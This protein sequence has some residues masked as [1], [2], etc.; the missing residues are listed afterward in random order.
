MLGYVAKDSGQGPHAERRVAWHGD[1]VFTTL[2]G[3]EAKMASGLTGEPVTQSTEGL[4]EIV[5][6]DVP[7]DP[8]AGMTSSR[9]KWSLMIRGA[10]P[11]LK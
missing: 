2:R 7:R 5:P 8:Q 11:G 6:R 10:W 9:T 3:G 4:R 1:M